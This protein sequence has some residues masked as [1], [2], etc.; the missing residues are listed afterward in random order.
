MLIDDGEL[1]YTLCVSRCLHAS[2]WRALMWAYLSGLLRCMCGRPSSA[3]HRA[4]W[5]RY[6]LRSWTSS[7][8]RLPAQ[9]GHA[10]QHASSVRWITHMLTYLIPKIDF[11]A[12]SQTV[13][14][15]PLICSC[16]AH[17]TSLYLPRA[18]AV[19][20][21]QVKV[22]SAINH[23]LWQS[24]ELVFSFFRRLNLSAVVILCKSDANNQYSTHSQTSYKCFCTSH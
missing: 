4:L 13:S 14:A 3:T 5:Q 22:E 19:I 20:C 17:E 24:C 18:M 21:I 15:W 11:S 2:T 23:L 1:V 10:C 7:L 12:K 6:C 9:V 16:K 8:R